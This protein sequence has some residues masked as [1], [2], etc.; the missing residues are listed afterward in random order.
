VSN[1]FFVPSVFFRNCVNF[2]VWQPLDT[3]DVI[4]PLQYCYHNTKNT[5]SKQC[6]NVMCILPVIVRLTV[7]FGVATIAGVAEENPALAAGQAMLM[8]ARVSHSHQETIVDL[9]PTAL[10]HL[11]R[12]LTLDRRCSTHAASTTNTTASNSSASS[13][14][15]CIKMMTFYLKETH[16]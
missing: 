16:L 10:T 14:H 5:K 3:A 13:T 6:C 12:L 1:V 2:V 9:L 7:E 11:V 4:F 15:L 8:P